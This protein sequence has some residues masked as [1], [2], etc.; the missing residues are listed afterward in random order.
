MKCHQN[1]SKVLV[2][3]KEMAAEF[4]K[5]FWAVRILIGIPNTNATGFA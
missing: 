4:F 5:N 1:A 3:K 2:G